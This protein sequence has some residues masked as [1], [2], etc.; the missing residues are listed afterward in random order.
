M[1]LPGETHPIQQT[2]E[3][4]LPHLSQP[5]L[6]GRVLWVSGAV[7]SPAAPVRTPSPALS[8]PAVADATVIPAGVAVE[9]GW[10]VASLSVSFSILERFLPSA[11]APGGCPSR[12]RSRASGRA[13]EARRP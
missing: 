8:Q 5:Q 2:I 13:G 1:R 10:L 4:H 11:V 9:H 12:Q 7:L 6:T 3:T